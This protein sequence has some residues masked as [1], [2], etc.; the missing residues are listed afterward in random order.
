MEYE[1]VSDRHLSRVS[2]DLIGAMEKLI[3]RDAPAFVPYDAFAV[4]A[5][6]PGVVAVTLV[7]ESRNRSDIQPS[8]YAFINRV[9]TIAR[10]LSDGR[11]LMAS[12][13]A[14]KLRRMVV[15]HASL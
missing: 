12:Y 9:A 5:C 7:L 15:I 1:R 3:P 14:A 6:R 11:F 4:P 10:K 8:L 2:H 13:G